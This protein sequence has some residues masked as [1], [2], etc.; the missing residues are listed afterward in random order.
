MQKDLFAGNRKFLTRLFVLV[1]YFSQ[2]F[3]NGIES[4]LCS[5]CK[6][7]FLKDATHV[8]GNG[9]FVDHKRGRYFLI[10]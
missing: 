7:E 9:T 5:I 4:R 1:L 2:S 8:F 3:T 10:T 6:L